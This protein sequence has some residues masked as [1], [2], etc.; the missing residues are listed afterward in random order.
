MKIQNR[1]R[2]LI[3]G[4]G[5]M[6]GRALARELTARHEVKALTHA[7]LDVSDPGAVETAVAGFRPHV[8]AHLGAWTD[9]DGCELD[10]AK[11]MRVNGDGTANVVKSA[12]RHHCRVLYVSTDYVFDGT[13]TSPIQEEAQTHPINA[14]GRSKLAGEEA[15]KTLPEHYIVRTSWV[16]G[17]GGK[18]FVDTIARVAFEKDTIE[19][20]ED[21]LGCPT[22]AADLAEALAKILESRFFGIFHVTNDTEC[23]WYVFAQQILKLVGSEARLTPVESSSLDRPAPRPRYSVLGNFRLHHV[24]AHRTRTWREALAEYLGERVAV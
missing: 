7:Q 19:M 9:V 1:M 13:A 22:Y 21:Q 18:N 23:T 11:A 12:R 4:A 17:E 6:V 3:T 8:I 10:P 2:V 24:L 5:G 16:F 15:V 20:V 14:Y